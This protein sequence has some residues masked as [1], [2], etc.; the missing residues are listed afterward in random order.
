ML[1]IFDASN[2][3]T[4]ICKTIDHYFGNICFLK[5]LRNHCWHKIWVVTV[6]R[7]AEFL[8]L[9]FNKWEIGVYFGPFF[10]LVK[11]LLGA[12]TNGAVFSWLWFLKSIP[13]QFTFKLFNSGEIL[14][15]IQQ[16]QKYKELMMFYSS[17][18]LSMT[19]SPF[20][21]FL[22]ILTNLLPSF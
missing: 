9:W 19:D 4:D 18:F 15:I 13:L 12:L 10:V 17:C 7:S 1:L 2:L 21:P 22:S 5:K 16:C 11:D 8:V 14:I 6:S 3:C 20:I